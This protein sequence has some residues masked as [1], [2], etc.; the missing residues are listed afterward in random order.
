MR[1]DSLTFGFNESL[2]NIT[3]GK[4]NTILTG[5][6]SPSH[7]HPVPLPKKRDAKRTA[8]TGFQI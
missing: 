6:G 1:S 7:P 4:K 2:R 3:Y 8:V 5:V